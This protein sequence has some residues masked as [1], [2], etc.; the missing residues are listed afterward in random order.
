MAIEKILII[1]DSPISRKIIKS[2]IPK[3]KGYDFFEA[4]DG[5]IGLEKFKEIHP[6]VTFLDLTMPVM[7]GVECLEK[8]L[9]FSKN[10]MVVVVTADVQIKSISK[11]TEIG[12]FRVIK[13]PPT[14]E[15]IEKVLI[16]IQNNS[17]E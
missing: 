15:G 16:D 11:V 12:A 14:K 13:K 1:D 17:G 10:A 4:E 9:N 8:I 2:C 3:D 7:G 6:E 5:K